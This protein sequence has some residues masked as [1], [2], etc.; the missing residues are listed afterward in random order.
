M[1]YTVKDFEQDL[2]SK[3]SRVKPVLLFC[4]QLMGKNMQKFA[5]GKSA[6]EFANVVI[7]VL[8]TNV[9][10][11]TAKFLAYNLYPHVKGN[12][13][14]ILKSIGKWEKEKNTRK[15]VKSL[16]SVLQKSRLSLTQKNSVPKK[17]GFWG[18]RIA[19]I[20]ASK[21]VIGNRVKTIMQSG[22]RAM[23][24]LFREETF[25]SASAPI[26]KNKT[27]LGTN[28]PLKD[29]ELEDLRVE[30]LVSFNKQKPHAWVAIPNERELLRAR[31][32]DVFKILRSISL[33]INLTREQ[34][35]F[36]NFLKNTLMI[37]SKLLW[38][39]EIIINIINQG[40]RSYNHTLDRLSKIC[41]KRN[42]NRKIRDYLHCCTEIRLKK[43]G[44]LFRKQFDRV[45]NIQS[46]DKLLDSYTLQSSTVVRKYKDLAIISNV[47]NLLRA[48]NRNP[49]KLDVLMNKHLG[50]HGETN[51]KSKLRTLLVTSGSDMEIFRKIQ[52]EKNIQGCIN[53]LRRSSGD[54]TVSKLLGLID[55][56]MRPENRTTFGGFKASLNFVCPALA[57]RVEA[58]MKSHVVLE[59]NR[60]TKTLLNS[61]EAAITRLNSLTKLLMMPKYQQAN[62]SIFET[63]PRSV[64]DKIKVIKGSNSQQLKRNIEHSFP[65]P[66]F[67]KSL[68]NLVTQAK[69]DQSSRGEKNVD[70]FYRALQDIENRVKRRELT[71]IKNEVINL[72]KSYGNINF[73]GTKSQQFLNGYAIARVIEDYYRNPKRDKIDLSVDINP[74]VRSKVKAMID[75]ER[76]RQL[77]KL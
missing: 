51:I 72:F 37:R 1:P 58:L 68:R 70:N 57:S 26:K 66:E 41:T 56:F 55:S 76:Q 52:R 62:I 7:L 3:P 73:S 49:Q 25:T 14:P 40:M 31:P 6:T 38:E 43:H 35:K 59:L 4:K 69:Q 28:S 5:A 50:K 19:T 10:Q 18:N 63:S 23:K 39:D 22:P 8:D 11:Q 32:V 30:T 44:N 33:M 29:K 16:C 27:I 34:K 45:A 71:L 15:V 13:Q 74:R 36:V 21:K 67:P 60:E 64:A 54:A 48:Y 42:V 2:L 75:S 77:Q 47:K 9:P 53:V 17:K 46:L 65:S 12:S 24:N 20:S 61:K